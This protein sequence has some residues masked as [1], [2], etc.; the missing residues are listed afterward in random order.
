M[1]LSRPFL[2]RLHQEYRER[3]RRNGAYS[4]RSF[5]R[6]LQ[7]NPGRLSQ[8]FS[9]ARTVTPKAAQRIMVRLGLSPIE[10]ARWMGL[11]L[12]HSALPAPMEPALLDQRAFELISEPIHFTLLS[13]METRGFRSQ[14]RWIASRIRSS[15]P[16]VTAALKLLSELGLAEERKGTWVPTHRQ[17]VR[18]SDGVQNA[19][20]RRA[21]E[22]QL[23]DAR[24]S[25]DAIALE[26]RDVTSITVATDPAK[27]GEARALIKDFRRKM[28]AV[29]E[30]GV[31]SEVYRLQI[32]LIPLTVVPVEKSHDK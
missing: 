1:N 2:E 16:E 31:P 25:L 29:L 23:E 20:L 5:S 12:D 6:D 27:L 13:L 7:I 24:A 10:Q 32:Q 18:S 21:H 15:V 30:D 17:G 28:A 9:G 22:R 3:R 26:W 4:L 8:Y 19:A 14:P 11:A